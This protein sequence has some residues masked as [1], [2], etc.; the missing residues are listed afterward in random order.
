MLED[1]DVLHVAGG[2]YGIYNLALSGGGEGVTVPRVIQT[3]QLEVDQ[4]MKVG[5]VEGEH[6]GA[7]I[8]PAWQGAVQSLAGGLL[9]VVAMRALAVGQTVWH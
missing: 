6:K 4:I 7:F 3:L 5:P 8:I 2:G 1:D 9:P